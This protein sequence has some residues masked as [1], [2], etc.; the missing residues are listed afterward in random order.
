MTMTFVEE[1]L[2]FLLRLLRPA[3]R[4]WV[5]A[6]QELPE[7]RRTMDEIVARAEA[8]AAFQAALVADLE[9]ALA[10]EGYEPSRPLLDELRR[11]YPEA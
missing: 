8:D 10:R 3:P 4:G 2:G 7:A 11:L 9:A 5:E 1:R 6:A